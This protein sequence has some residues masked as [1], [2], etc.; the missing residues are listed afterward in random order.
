[1]KWLEIRGLI[2]VFTSVKGF[3]CHFFPD[4]PSSASP[5]PTTATKNDWQVIQQRARIKHSES[6]K[7]S[8]NL[9]AKPDAILVKRINQNVSFASVL[10]LMK[11]KVDWQGETKESG[12][13]IFMTPGLRGFFYHKK[14]LCQAVL[15][16]GLCVKSYSSWKIEIL[17]KFCDL[18]WYICTVVRIQTYT[19]NLYIL[20]G[21]YVIQNT[22]NIFLLSK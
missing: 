17:A 14:R 11:E 15:S 12:T 5:A 4:P 9:R 6:R 13:P 3:V 18:H 8:S 10:K 7:L 21:F 20:I 1:M 2:F 22:K 19:H 16:I